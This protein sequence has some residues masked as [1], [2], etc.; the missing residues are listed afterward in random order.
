M[1]QCSKW[2]YTFPI[3]EWWINHGNLIR[4]VRISGRTGQTEYECRFNRTG[5][6]LRSSFLETMQ[7]GPKQR[8]RIKAAGVSLINRIR[9]YEDTDNWTVPFAFTRSLV[10]LRIRIIH[11]FASVYFVSSCF[12]DSS[13]PPPKKEGR[14]STTRHNYARSGKKYA[15]VCIPLKAF[16]SPRSI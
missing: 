8:I 4:L 15:E 3:R 7:R 11:I 9:E 16:S 13:F 12:R 5:I 10:Y 6:K 14:L 1:L 2:L